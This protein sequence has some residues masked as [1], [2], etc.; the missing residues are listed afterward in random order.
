VNA[1]RKDAALEIEKMVKKK[2]AA[3]E[4][5]DDI[6]ALVD[7]LASKYTR[8][9]CSANERKGG[10]LSLAAVAV[11][12][13]GSGSLLC[14]SKVFVERLLPPLLA[15]A[16]DADGRVRYYALEAVYNV[17]KST[18]PAILAKVP[19]LFEVLFK[20]C[21][22][23][24]TCVQNATIFVS[25]LLKDSIAGSPSY[26][27]GM[28]LETLVSCMPV[29]SS[30]KRRFLLGWISFIDSLPT[31]TE[32]FVASLPDVVPM[33][34]AYS[35]DS[36]PEVRHPA[37]KQLRHILGDIKGRSVEAPVQD[38]TQALSDSILNSEDDSTSALPSVLSDA[39]TDSH[40]KAETLKWLDVLVEQYYR[41][42]GFTYPKILKCCLKCLDSA[43][44][45]VQDVALELNGKLQSNLRKTEELNFLALLDVAVQKIGSV[46]ELAKLE[47]LKWTAL[48]M[49]TDY[50]AAKQ[51]KPLVLHS[52]CD[53]LSSAS[54]E[55]VQQAVVVLVRTII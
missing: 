46:Q 43:D 53:A 52:L 13:A 1:K 32:D 55:V 19:S 3:G 54:D 21:D 48:L 25:D 17:V 23:T 42:L 45:G 4:G 14:Q 11:G 27:V 29:Q 41:K 9:T 5:N 37:D 47:A 2:V 51:I 36:V 49:K 18:R 34:L 31:S 15:G 20:L 12:L 38:L 33:L 7:T 24:D 50:I 39:S 8:P 28:L 6:L 16:V 10:M 44:F 26:R 35:G 40:V 22:D 30:D